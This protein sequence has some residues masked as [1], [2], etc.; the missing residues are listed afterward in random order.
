MT[1]NLPWKL[2]ANILLFQIGWFSCI[3][4]DAYWPIIIT[5]AILLIHFFYVCS[6][7]IN[8]K[9]TPATE[10]LLLFKVLLIGLAVE[11]MYLWFDILIRGDS[12]KFPPLWLLCIW[13]LFATTLRHSLVW[14]RTNTLLSIAFAA[15]AAPGSYYAG[16]QLN[17]MMSLGAPT[18]FSLLAISISWAI[19][20][21][22]MMRFLVS[23][24]KP[25]VSRTIG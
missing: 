6:S 3:A 8:T 14:L 17:S 19:V 12:V 2:I 13:I 4:L 1:L 9:V 15:I 11:L 22:L 21:P 10:G 23:D 25:I 18:L 7:P 5:V 20:F 24:P 16:A